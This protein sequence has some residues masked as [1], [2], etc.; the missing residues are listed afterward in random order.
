M[1]V[2]GKI[3]VFINLLFSL[4]VGGLI[5]TVF[6]AR[7]NWKDYATKVRQQ[8]DLADAEANTWKAELAAARHDYDLAKTASEK[9]V[10]DRDTEIATFKQNMRALTEQLAAANDRAMKGDTNVTSVNSEIQRR[11][12]EVKQLSDQ[13]VKL[14]ERNGTLEKEKNFL[15]ENAVA[16]QI[17]AKAVGDRNKQ[18]EEKI[19]EKEKELVKAKTS[20][21]GTTTTLSAKNPPLENIQGRVKEYDARSGLMTLDIGS[22]AGLTAGHTLELFRLNPA[23]YLGTI[24]I[25]RVTPHEAIAQPLGRLQGPVQK[26]D[27]AASKILGS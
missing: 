18:L 17:E 3:L 11:Q 1:T 2:V 9:K 13:V 24:R 12:L 8:Y 6:I 5:L 26:S 14:Q 19:Q 4:V 27:T 7:T 20:G 22:D 10:A 15:R 16:A 21:G 23:K 25:M